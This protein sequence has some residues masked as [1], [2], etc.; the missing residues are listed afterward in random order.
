MLPVAVEHSEGEHTLS[1]TW[2]VPSPVYVFLAVGP[3]AV[4]PSPKNHSILRSSESGLL[5]R[6]VKVTSRGL[7]PDAGDE[8]NWAT[9]GSFRRPATAAASLARASKPSMLASIWAAVSRATSCSFF[10][11][12]TSAGSRAKWVLMAAMSSAE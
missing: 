12:G 3:S 9:T 7:G 1:A 4:F 8:L 2:Y 10:P 5:D 11:T 6:S